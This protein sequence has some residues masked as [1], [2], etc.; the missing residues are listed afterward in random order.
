MKRYWLNTHLHKNFLLVLISNAVSAATGFLISILLARKLNVSDY[1][2]FGTLSVIM[3]MLP[4][5]LDFGLSTSIVRHIGSNKQTEHQTLSTVLIY[6]LIT[7]LLLTVPFLLLASHLSTLLLNDDSY[8]TYLIVVWG[9]ALLLNLSYA[10]QAVTQ[11]FAELRNYALFNLLQTLLRFLL[12]WAIIATGFPTI[13]NLVL[14][15]AISCIAPFLWGMLLFSKKIH[16]E[17]DW[18]ILSSLLNFAKWVG[19]S[20]F[21]AV[22]L[23]RIDV[24][25]LNRLSNRLEVAYYIAAFQLAFVFPLVTMSLTNSLLPKVTS[26]AGRD[27]QREYVYNVIKFS[28]LIFAGCIFLLLSADQIIQC[29][30]GARYIHAV[31]PFKVLLPVFMLGMIITPLGMIVY[32]LERPELNTVLFAV[33]IIINLIVDY[34]LVPTYGAVGAAWGTV[35]AKVAA[36][37]IVLYW[38]WIYVYRKPRQ[39]NA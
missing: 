12:I 18:A 38:V 14:A 3:S 24:F 39:V 37:V 30:F 10:F 31:A 36:A 13:G 33:Q 8:V 28:P 16:F 19:F 21:L 26:L 17:F 9:G 5:M 7:S 11:T 25:M 15:L 34:L 29:L 2:L 27:S 35:A 22:F 23:M 1:G 6:K 32:P 4:M 20:S